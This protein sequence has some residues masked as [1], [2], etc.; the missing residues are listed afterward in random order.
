MSGR[1]DAIPKWMQ[2]IVDCAELLGGSILYRDFGS[3]DWVLFCAIIIDLSQKRTQ[4]ASECM[5]TMV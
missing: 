3:L 2:K 4:L 5:F 1:Q